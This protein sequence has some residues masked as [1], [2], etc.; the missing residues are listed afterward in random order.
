MRR[1]GQIDVLAGVSCLSAARCVAAGGSISRADRGVTLAEAWNGRRWRQRNTPA[2]V[3]R[4]RELDM[5]ETDIERVFRTFNALA[6]A[7]ADFARA[8]DDPSQ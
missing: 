1:S 8:D 7:G 4:L 2:L 5:T 3:P 6:F